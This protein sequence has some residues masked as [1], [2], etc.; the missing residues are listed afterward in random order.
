MLA[1]PKPT[2]R[3]GEKRARHGSLAAYKK[4]CMEIW[5]ERG[6]KCEKCGRELL[7]PRWHNFNHTAGRTIHF[8]GK[9]TIE[10]L[11]FKCH[12]KYGGI[13]ETSTWLDN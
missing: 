1:F 11:C 7:S 3:K 2:K 9:D 4:I 10:L 12:C 13:K 6:E 5:E 8:L